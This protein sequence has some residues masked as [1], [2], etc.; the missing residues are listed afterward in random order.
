VSSGSF[1]LSRYESDAGDIYSIRVQPETLTANIGAV[2]AAPAGAVT[3]PISARAR[4]NRGA[5]GVGARTVRVRFTGAVPDNYAPNQTLS[6]PILTPANFTTI[7]KGT[8]GTY[9]GSPV[10]VVGKTSESVV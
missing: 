9:L 3:Q 2:N 1:T 7:Q 6:V 5:Y 4:K 8:T 10:V